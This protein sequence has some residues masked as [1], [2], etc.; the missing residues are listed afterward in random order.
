MTTQKRLF[1]KDCVLGLTG[2]ANYYWKQK[3]TLTGA[4]SQTISLKEQW[5]ETVKITKDLQQ[6]IIK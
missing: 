4:I 2:E 3:N 1:G 5:A 6:V